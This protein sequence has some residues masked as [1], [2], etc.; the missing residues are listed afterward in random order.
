VQLS[1]PPARYLLQV[2]PD[3]LCGLLAEEERLLAFAALVLGAQSPSEVATATGLPARDTVRALR[4]LEQGGLVIAEGGK[5]SASVTVFKEAIREYGQPSAQ[6]EPLDPDQAK[7][8]VLRAFIRDGRL[9]SIPAARGKRQVILEHIA[10]CFEPGVRYPERAVDAVLR[11]WH[12]DYVSLR[13]YLIDEDMMA[14]E[15]GVYW[16]SGGPVEV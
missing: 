14:R 12:E 11:A 10:A 9:V 7:S 6:A 13:R 16:R 8:A 4:R 5:L 2:R 1:Q 15:D 3:A